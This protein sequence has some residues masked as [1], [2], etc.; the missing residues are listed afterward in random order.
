PMPGE[1]IG[2]HGKHGAPAMIGAEPADD[3]A[4]LIAVK[5]E[6]GRPADAGSQPPL[7]RA[8][9]RRAQEDDEGGPS[10]HPAQRP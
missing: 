5:T 9:L 1:T 2:R 10:P 3:G 8:P 6:G 7:D 4:A